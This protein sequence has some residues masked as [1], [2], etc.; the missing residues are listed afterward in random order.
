MK[1]CHFSDACMRLG[2]GPGAKRPISPALES[3]FA[4][5]SQ[6]LG[7][8]DGS[9]AQPAPLVDLPDDGSLGFNRSRGESESYGNLVGRVTL[10]GHREDLSEVRRHELVE[11]ALK[12]E[13]CV[14]QVLTGRHARAELIDVQIFWAK[15][16][17]SPPRSTGS[18]S[19]LFFRPA[20]P[21]QFQRACSRSTVVSH[22]EPP[23]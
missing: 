6:G 11:Q 2:D 21:G 17:P 1:L 13:L 8:Y 4:S 15:S 22:P 19:F 5:A 18:A 14:D 9:I 23:A 10:V 20:S 16:L 3:L 12:L 7:P